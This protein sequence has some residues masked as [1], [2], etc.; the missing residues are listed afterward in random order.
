MTTLLLP[1]IQIWPEGVRP[2]NGTDHGLVEGAAGVGVGDG[3]GEAVHGVDVA[4]GDGFSV[5]TIV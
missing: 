4:V 2:R 3:V 1:L 5:D